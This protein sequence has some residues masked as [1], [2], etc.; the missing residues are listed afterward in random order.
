MLIAALVILVML[1]LFFGLV[2]LFGPPYLPTL[3]GQIQTALDMLDLQPGQTMLE[4]GSGDGRVMRAAAARGWNVVGVELNLFLVIISYIR[5][6][7]YRKQVRVIWG[8]VWQVKWP[9]ADGVFTFMLQRQMG[10]L[11]SRIQLWRQGRAVRLASF[12]FHL[13][14]QKPIAEK[15]GVYLYEYPVHKPGNERA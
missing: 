11:D 14:D 15:D 3:A 9:V 7:K 5:C 12:A 1:I 10:K 8:N 6:W 4:L 2:V 13:P